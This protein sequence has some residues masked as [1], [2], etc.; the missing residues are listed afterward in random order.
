MRDLPERNTELDHVTLAYLCRLIQQRRQD[1][2]EKWW[3]DVCP[4][5]YHNLDLKMCRRKPPEL[6][7]PIRLLHKQLAAR[8]GHG[9][10]AARHRRLNH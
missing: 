6:A 5:R 7:I 2:V 3:S 1:L 10:F 8:T 9:D 4:A